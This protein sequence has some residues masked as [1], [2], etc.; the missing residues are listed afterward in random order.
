[1]R[2]AVDE[3]GGPGGG[4]FDV[5]DGIVMISSLMDMPSSCC[6]SVVSGSVADVANASDRLRFRRLRR[7]RAAA[8]SRQQITR[9]AKEN[10]RIR[11]SWASPSSAVTWTSGPMVNADGGGT[12]GGGTEVDGG[13]DGGV[14]SGD[15]GGGG[16]GSGVLGGGG[17]GSGGLGGGEDGGGVLGGGGGTCGLPSGTAG[18]KRGG[19]GDGGGTNGDGSNG[20][21]GDEGGGVDGGGGDSGGK[22][23]EVSLTTRMYKK[24]ASLTPSF[25]EATVTLGSRAS[26]RFTIAT[27]ASVPVVQM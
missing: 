11:M 9:Q 16:D 5:Q 26:S 24:K 2:R 27:A 4:R 7:K 8:S 3:D 23:R 13:V 18:G 17:D 1:M 21:G 20:S 10:G 19:G 12:D 25:A 15:M 6:A 14:G 22:Q